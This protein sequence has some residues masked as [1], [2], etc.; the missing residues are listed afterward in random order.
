MSLFRT[1]PIQ[2]R[3]RLQFR[4]EAFSLTNHPQWSNPNGSVTS[5]NFM[6]ITNTR[7]NTARNARLGI[8]LEF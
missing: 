8:R 4:A 6:R 7:S 1:F 2:G 3:V 5:S